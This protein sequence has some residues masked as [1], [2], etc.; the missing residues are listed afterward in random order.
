MLAVG[1][2]MAFTFLAGIGVSVG[3]TQIEPDW[4]EV[5]GGLG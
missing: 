2:K 5:R 1:G 3:A 4:V